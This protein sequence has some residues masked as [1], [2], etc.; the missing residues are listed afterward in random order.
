MKDQP[1]R[2]AVDYLKREQELDGSWFGR[3]GVNYIYGTTLVLRGLEAMG[4]DNHDAMI[5]QAAEW[6][7]S[8]Q[9]PDG[10]WGETVGSYD[11]P[12]LRG[13]GSSTASTTAWP[14]LG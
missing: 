4:V 12:H 11:R 7:R 5:Q 8:V 14:I 1:V 13:Q 2:R 10:G 9:N 6:L 3:W